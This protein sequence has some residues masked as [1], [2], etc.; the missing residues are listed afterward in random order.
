MPSDPIEK[1][2]VRTFP[3]GPLQRPPARRR[4]RGR[5]LFLLLVVAGIAFGIYRKV[6]VHRADTPE[7]VPVSGPAAVDPVARQASGEGPEGSERFEIRHQLV[8]AGETIGQI[9]QDSGISIEYLDRWEK[10]CKSNLFAALKENDEL[11]FVVD[12]GD[13]HP[14]KLIYSPREGPAHI[15][16]ESSAGWECGSQG[17]EKK[18]PVYTAAGRYAGNFHD[19]CRA[20]G[21]PEPLIASLA[22]IF[23]CHVDFSSDLKD[24]GAFAVYYQEQRIRGTE[25]KQFLILAAEITAGQRIL[26][27]FGFELPDGA[28][29]YFDAKGESLKG[30]F[31]KNPLDYRWLISPG[32]A[33]NVRPV[34]RT[35]RPHIG[36]DYAAPRGAP[37]S[38]VGDGVISSLKRYGKSGVLIEVRHNDGYRS[39]YGRLSEYARGLEVGSLLSRGEVIGSVGPGDGAE[40]HLD[41]RFF[42]KGRTIDFRAADFPCT[43]S[44]PDSEQSRFEKT[45]DFYLTALQGGV[46]TPRQQEIP[47]GGE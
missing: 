11:I 37:V 29:D 3:K 43:R 31:S 24:G 16:R 47:P 23:A 33:E 39:Y 42:K 25:G 27:A 40:A 1:L 44:I 22:D 6:S 28:W 4:V 5:H 8:G 9:L 36:I 46:P 38:V 18:E 17:P 21:V 2:T 7:A 20:G 26:Q 34:L 12:R 41:F 45:R 15:L 14:L 32:F 30:P 35:Y 13:G 10:A 19:S